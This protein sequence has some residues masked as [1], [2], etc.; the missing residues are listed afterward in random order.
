MTAFSSCMSLNQLRLAFYGSGSDRRKLPRGGPGAHVAG[1]PVGGAR[2][3]SWP[4]SRGFIA[5]HFQPFYLHGEVF[6]PHFRQG[7][8]APGQLRPDTLPAWRSARQFQVFC[9]SPK[10]MPKSCTLFRHLHGVGNNI[11]GRDSIQAKSSHRRLNSITASRS[12]MPQLGAQARFILGPS[13][14]ALPLRS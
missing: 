6:P 10:R 2:P 5:G 11:A 13:T 14:T 12:P 7:A 8:H 9:T 1:A 3:A 4:R